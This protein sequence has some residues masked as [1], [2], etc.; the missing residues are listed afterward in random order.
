[1]A[2]R[3]ARRSSAAVRRPAAAASRARSGSGGRPSARTSCPACRGGSRCAPRA[4]Y[5]L[6]PVPERRGLEPSGAR[7]R[8]T[9]REAGHL[10][11]G[12]EAGLLRAIAAGDDRAFAAFY[13]RW[14]G[15]VFRYC[16]LRLGDSEAADA[17]QEV[18]LAVWR[19]A[20][21]YHSEGSV[22]AWVFA[23]ASRKVADAL[24]R[25]APAGARAEGGEA[26]DPA[27]PMAAAEAQ[28]D[29]GQALARLPPAQ[30]ETV[31]LAYA[32]DLSCAEVAAITGVPAGTVK[33]RL[34]H[35]RRALARGMGG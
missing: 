30:R 25:R 9:D 28:L 20:G 29:L 22:A 6:R 7:P 11:G 16:R 5:S 31:L 2:P 8:H 19:G 26:Q 35:A 13:D 27:D 18:L 14:A 10:A 24:R 12:E 1:M 3:P 15:R 33:S 32:F 23:I 34:H 4:D 21:R 17:A